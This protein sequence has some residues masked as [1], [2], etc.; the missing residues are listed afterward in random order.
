MD[1]QDC[2]L[3]TRLFP[4]LPA[5]DPWAVR[6][7]LNGKIRADEGNQEACCETT[8]KFRSNGRKS[9]LQQHRRATQWKALVWQEVIQDKHG[10]AFWGGLANR[11]DGREPGIW[12]GEAIKAVWLCALLRS[13]QRKSSQSGKSSHPARSVQDGTPSPCREQKE[14]FSP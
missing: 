1:Q 13:P 6:P 8:G 9:T 14:P 2:S 11:Q 10:A 7:P 3:T 5:K 12:A 4:Q